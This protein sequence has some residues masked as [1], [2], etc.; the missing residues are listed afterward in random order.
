LGNYGTASLF[1]GLT[2]PTAANALR[3]LAAVG[4]VAGRIGRQAPSEGRALPRNETEHGERK[5]PSCG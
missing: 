2:T 3:A 5:E 1:F 4:V